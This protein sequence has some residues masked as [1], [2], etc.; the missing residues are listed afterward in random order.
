[1]EIASAVV[2][3]ASVVTLTTPK[4]RPLERRTSALAFKILL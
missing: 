1:M 4:T 2:A 3:P